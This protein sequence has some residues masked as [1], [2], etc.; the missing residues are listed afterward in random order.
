MGHQALKTIEHQSRR[1]NPH[2]QISLALVENVDQWLLDAFVNGKRVIV[3]NRRTG[4]VRRGQ[5][6]ASMGWTP[7]LLLMPRANSRCSSDTLSG[8]DQMLGYA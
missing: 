2:K 5:V 4:E 1:L 3:Q 6:K 7:V 8:E